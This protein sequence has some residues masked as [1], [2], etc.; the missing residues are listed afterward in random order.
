MSDAVAT[1]RTNRFA[2]E[3]RAAF[4]TWLDTRIRPNLDDDLTVD[5]KDGMVL[6]GAYASPPNHNWDTGEDLDLMA[7]LA[8]HL[9]PGSV[10]LLLIAGHEKLRS[11]F[12]LAE[13][14]DAQGHRTSLDLHDIMKRAEEELEWTSIAPLEA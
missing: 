8:P 13:A 6:L 3:D 1:F 9:A 11:V 7:E 10:A 5:W 14:V 4:E 2:V 12:G